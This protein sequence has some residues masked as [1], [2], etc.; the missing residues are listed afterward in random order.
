MFAE[1]ATHLGSAM[2]SFNY[3]SDSSTSAV[4]TNNGFYPDIKVSEFINAWKLP[5]EYGEDTVINKLVLAVFEVNQALADWMAD[6]VSQ[7]YSKLEDIPGEMINSL[8]LFSASYVN[9]VSYC[10]KESLLDFYSSVEREENSEELIKNR[11]ALKNTLK[12]EYKTAI[13]VFLGK[14]TFSAELL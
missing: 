6:Q 5:T 11:R 3:H 14:S 4:I 2:N 12:R 9:A 13:N 10:A 7:G 8:S 1:T